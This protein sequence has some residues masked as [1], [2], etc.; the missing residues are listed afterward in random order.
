MQKTNWSNLMISSASATPL[1]FSTL[2]CAA[3]APLDVVLVVV[4]GLLA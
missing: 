3:G 2:C 1:T 4:T